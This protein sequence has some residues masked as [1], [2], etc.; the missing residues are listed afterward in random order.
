MPT[1]FSTF[2]RPAFALLLS[3]GLWQGGQAQAAPFRPGSRVE[4]HVGSHWA[5]CM[6]VG[7]QLPTGGYRLH[8]DSLPDP[9]YV[10]SETDVREIGA[11]QPAPINQPAAPPQGRRVQGR[12]AGAWEGCVMIGGQLPT[13]G[14]LLRC[15]S[16]PNMESVFSATDVRF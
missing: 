12:V 7:D 4:G 9:E 13:G 16:N 6:V 3:A 10:F 8:C 1:R 14:Y 11:A 5:P 15:D 2:A